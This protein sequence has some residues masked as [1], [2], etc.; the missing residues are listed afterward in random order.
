MSVFWTWPRTPVW[1]TDQTTR[2]L[3][4]QEKKRLEDRLEFAMRQT[5]VAD[6]DEESRD[7]ES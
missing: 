4:A 2:A 3:V 5:S 1:I 6:R 7:G